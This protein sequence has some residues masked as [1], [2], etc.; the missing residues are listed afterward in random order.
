MNFRG[1]H[2]LSVDQFEPDDIETIFRVAVQMEPFARREKVT[3][4]L[5]G[6]VLGNLFFEASTRTRVSFGSAF[7]R[8]GGSVCS[9]TG[10]QSS[11]FSKGESIYDT[12]RVVSGYVDLIVIRHPEEGAVREF[13]NATNIPVIN[14][15]D[16]PGEHPTQ[17][18]LD[19]YT[20]T[21]ELERKPVELAGITIALVG[22]LKFGRTVHSLAKLLAKYA[23]MNFVFISPP[24]LEMPAHITDRLRAL[25]HTV[26]L[27]QD[28]KAGIRQADVIYVTRVQEE[29]FS[30]E[31]EAR[32]FRGSYAVNRALLDQHAPRCKVVLHPLPRDSRPEANEL[33]CD[34]N[35]DRRLA[36]FRQADNGIPIR[37]A[38][39]ALV[40]GVEDQIAASIRPVNWYVPEFVGVQDI[41]PL[42]RSPAE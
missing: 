2:I 12:S 22:D 24:G 10:F 29:R 6:A 15:G 34:L 17:A 20:M 28:I 7:E 14:G 40:L 13:A 38:L 18:L 4:V 36:I 32:K 21:R 41:V 30:S 33:D 3:R 27:T 42:R 16:G 9:T 31:S 1:S 19:L 25:G 26:V 35:Q 37:M 39:Y 8:L 23:C 5:E 11:S